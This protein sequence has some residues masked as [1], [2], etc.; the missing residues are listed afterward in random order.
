MS[1]RLIEIQPAA[2]S[3]TVLMAPLANQQC[4]PD[5]DLFGKRSKMDTDQ[6]AIDHL[7]NAIPSLPRN[8]SLDGIAQVVDGLKQFHL[9]RW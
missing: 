8:L 1:Q 7:N 9:L 2:I 6:L 5:R 4:L 3:R